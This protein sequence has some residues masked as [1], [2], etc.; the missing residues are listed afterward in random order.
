LYAGF[1]GI[2]AEEFHLG[3]AAVPDHKLHTSTAQKGLITVRTKTREKGVDK[4]GGVLD[5]KQHNLKKDNIKVNIRTVQP[6]KNSLQVMT[7]GRKAW[8]IYW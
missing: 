3:E 7:L 5:L 1:P 4:K 8:V 6:D 2:T